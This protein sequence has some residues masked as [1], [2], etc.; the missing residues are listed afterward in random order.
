MSAGPMSQVSVGMMEV[1]ME[2]QPGSRS[3]SYLEDRRNFIGVASWASGVLLALALLWMFGHYGGVGWWTFVV[4]V[5]LL[6]GRVWALVMWPV[7][8]SI[9]NIEEPRADERKKE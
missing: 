6:S 5:A 4:V 3:R 1:K 8:K 9:Y 2:L 7:F